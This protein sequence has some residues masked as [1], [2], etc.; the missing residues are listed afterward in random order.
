M[1]GNIPALKGIL[2]L[3]VI[4]AALGYFVDV[5]DLVIFSIVRSDSLRD[6]GVPEHS[7]FETGALLLNVQ[8][9]GMLLGGLIWGMAGDKKGRI[10]VLFSSIL[11]YSVA[12]IA[13][14]FVTSVEQYAVL[15]F[16]SGFGL[17]GEIGGAV[18][19]VTELLPREKRGLAATLVAAIGVSGALASCLVAR[20]ADWQ[21]T[22]L[23]GGFLGLMLLGLRFRVMESG[24]FEK[25]A[26]LEGVQRG[27][28]LM[29]F[30][31]WRR[32]VKYVSCILVGVPIYYY[33][34]VFI[35]FSP[36]LTKTLGA[37][38]PV[39]AGTALFA[40]YVGLVLG[41]MACGLTSQYFRSRRMAMAVFLAGAMAACC[42]YLL[43]PPAMTPL[44]FYAIG[45]LA[46]F[47]AG[48][49]AVFI[50]N[51]AEQFGTNLRATVA[52]TAPNFVRAATIPV[53]A[54]YVFLKP[55]IG[56]VE[57][58][59]AVGAVCFAIGFAALWSLPETY[60]KEMDYLER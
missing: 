25:T 6:I 10:S 26:A 1:N 14:A 11:L 19:L 60:G 50:M 32:F 39:V 34:T 15:R 43:S 54:G 42:M 48:Y 56:L 8:M 38:Q 9:A 22:Y 17:A 41:D 30:H 58:A 55:E 21:T 29:L 2:T 44:W 33:I 45:G 31:P 13:N 47:F 49:W 40:G 7:V 51:S 57:S 23:I 36:E 59:F 37:T 18:T 12:N 52:T 35:V 20:I 53:T 46:G 16:V 28:F 27:N 4:V 5:Y 24:M 3:P